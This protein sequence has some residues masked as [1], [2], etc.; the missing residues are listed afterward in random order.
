MAFPFVRQKDATQVRVAVEDH[1]EEIKGLALVPVGCAP[2]A[3]HS[4]NVRVVIVQENFQSQAMILRRLEQMVINLEARLF[5]GAAISAAKVCEE[6][7]FK[8][9]RG[10]QI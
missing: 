3:R 1:S 9:G 10:L 2:D 5:F 4:L 8:S 6:I 7:E